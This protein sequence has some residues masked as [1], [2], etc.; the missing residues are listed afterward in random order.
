MVTDWTHNQ[1]QITDIRKLQHLYAITIDDEDEF[2]SLN[3]NSVLINE[4]IFEERI[5]SYFLKHPTNI[6][7]EDIMKVLWNMHITKGYY[8]KL[9]DG[10]FIKKELDADKFY[11]SFLEI[12]GPLGS[13]E[14]IINKNR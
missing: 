4:S 6:S 12:E 11:V 8:V 10:E 13:F 1:I 2:M 5:S 7:R 14:N 9:R 3:G